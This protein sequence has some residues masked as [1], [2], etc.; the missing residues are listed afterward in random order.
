MFLRWGEAFA[1]PYSCARLQRC[2]WVRSGAAAGGC[3]PLGSRLPHSACS[4]RVA[5]RCAAAT[6]QALGVGRARR[7]AHR[8]EP[9]RRRAALAR[10]RGQCAARGAALAASRWR[11]AAWF[12]Q[13]PARAAPARPVRAVSVGRRAG[14]RPARLPPSCRDAV[15]KRSGARSGARGGCGG[16]E[17]SPRDVTLRCH[18]MSAALHRPRVPPSADVAVKIM[19]TSVIRTAC[20]EV[21]ALTRLNH[22]HVV[23]LLSVQVRDAHERTP[24]GALPHARK[25]DDAVPPPLAPAVLGATGRRPRSA[26]RR[27]CVRR[28]CGCARALLSPPRAGRRP[29]QKPSR[30]RRLTCA[31][32]CVVCVAWAAGGHASGA[33]VRVDG[34]VPG[35]RAF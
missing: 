7:R 25:G 21:M 10:H 3:G 18:S 5:D 29:L 8:A 2:W 15:H 35:R 31:R 17:R 11:L 12:P 34:V 30:R 4:L 9:T 20:K 24:V 27:M 23:Q 22:P 13:L 16:G 19:P 26:P 33:R 14:I 6:A 28:P 1:R 32:P